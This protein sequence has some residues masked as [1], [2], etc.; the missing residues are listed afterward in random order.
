M[1]F[2]L[3][4]LLM[5]YGTWITN[6]YRGIANGTVHNVLGGLRDGK[7][8][9]GGGE[10][11]VARNLQF[12][13]ARQYPCSRVFFVRGRAESTLPQLAAA[14]K[15][16]RFAIALL[17]LDTDWFES[18]LAELQTMLP[19]LSP[20]GVVVSDDYFFLGGARRGVE[21]YFSAAAVALGREMSYRLSSRQFLLMRNERPATPGDDE[22]N[23]SCW[24]RY[25]ESPLAGVRW[26]N[27]MWCL[28]RRYVCVNASEVERLGVEDY[29]TPSVKFRDHQ[30]R[31]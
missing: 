17:R 4:T 21:T 7:W 16:S 12:L 27:M 31:A 29:G 26:S 22:R 2:S 18:T 20:G 3:S 15:G 11:E 25:H 9:F 5:D 14:S 28:H 10:H 13:T 8:A 24:Q 30:H 19:L 23:A 1:T 6:T